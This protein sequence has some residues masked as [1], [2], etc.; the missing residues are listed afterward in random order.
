MESVPDKFVLVCGCGGMEDRARRIL[1]AHGYKDYSKNIKIIKG[2]AIKKQGYDLWLVHN[3]MEKVK[4]YISRATFAVLISQQPKG[5]INLLMSNP[6]MLTD[7]M[8]IA[9]G[10]PNGE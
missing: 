9:L 7:G 6:K 8:K 2:G 3:G 5:S 10:E 1:L 4:Q